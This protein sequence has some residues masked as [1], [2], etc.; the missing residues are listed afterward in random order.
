[1]KYHTNQIRSI[2]SSAIPK[3]AKS[4]LLA[5]HHKRREETGELP[6]VYPTLTILKDRAGY[7]LLV[8]GIPKFKSLGALAICKDAN[9]LQDS[10]CQVISEG[11]NSALLKFNGEYV[12]V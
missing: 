9:S 6:D 3:H 4:Y 5:W 7:I 11:N 8:D 12:I 2:T 1:M 10:V